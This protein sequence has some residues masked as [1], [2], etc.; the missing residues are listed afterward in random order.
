MFVGPNIVTDGLILS[1]DAGSKK[2][3][4][5]SG[6][7]ITDLS[8]RNN[9][10]SLINGVSFT[11]SSIPRFELDG[12]NDRIDVPKDLNGFEHNVHYDIDWTIECW[13]YMHTPDTSPQSYKAIYGNYNGCNYSVYPGNAQGFVIYNANNPATL[14]TNFGFAAK[15]PSGCPDGIIWNNGDSSWVY[16]LAIN[17]WCQFVM[18]SYDGTTY[19]VYANG[20]QRGSTKTF[21][22]KNSA[23]RTAN[24]LTATRNYSWGA[25]FQNTG[26]NEVDF[27]V[28]KIYN[29]ALTAEEVLQNYNATK[30]RFGV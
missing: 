3:Y 6:T 9:S 12:T 20:Q 26:A 14:Y 24:N 5:G 7:N 19:K 17:K 23:G 15:S 1:L 8:G 4:P 25:N 18:T 28:M 27:S 11:N 22:Y 29:K 13:M 2:S 21:D 30:S 10:G 16:D